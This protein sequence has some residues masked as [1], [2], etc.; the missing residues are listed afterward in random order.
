MVREADA[1]VSE[2]DRSSL[3][4]LDLDGPLAERGLTIAA[5]APQVGDPVWL[6]SRVTRGGGAPVVSLGETRV[7]GVA[8]ERLAIG[9]SDLGWRDGTPVLNA[10]GEVL[11]L[12]SRDGRVVRV[13]PD[14]DRPEPAPRGIS[15]LPV[16]GLRLGGEAGGLF[17][18]AFTYDVEAGVSLWDRLAIVTRF[19]FAIG[20]AGPGLAPL[21]AVDGLGPGVAT[22]AGDLALRLG[23]E[24]RYRMYLGGAD[25]P[26]YID[27]AAGLQYSY[28]PGLASGPAFRSGD[29]AC[30]PLAEACP[31]QVVEPGVLPSRDALDASFGVDVRLGGVVLGYR[32]LPGLGDAP[33]AHQFTIGGAMF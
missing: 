10:A 25:F 18:G 22:T 19:G 2:E 30:D 27:L 13:D 17:D 20:D 9:A 23:L 6:I 3:W 26:V 31:L 28:A 1:R 5:G 8:P 29:L 4:I 16:V 12:L 24:A 11:G 21:P 32:L 15:V 33:M 7:T 14:A